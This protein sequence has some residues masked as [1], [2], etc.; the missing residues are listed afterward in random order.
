MQTIDAPASRAMSISCSSPGRSVQA[1]KPIPNERPSFAAVATSLLSWSMSCPTQPISPRPPAALTAPASAPPETPA[2]G[3]ETM[4]TCRSKRSVNHVLS[5]R[6]SWPVQL[7]AVSAYPHPLIPRSWRPLAL[8]SWMAAA[9]VLA[10]LS[11]HF[12][13]A[14]AVN[15]PD[16]IVASGLRA[17]LAAHPHLLSLAARLGSPAAV[18]GG[19]VLLAVLCLVGRRPKA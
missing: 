18:I 5:T 19:S 13:H 14:A 9:A 6:S 17:R 15:A 2:I 11:W 4:G 3:A 8:L 10:A 7:D 16:T 12:A 1:R